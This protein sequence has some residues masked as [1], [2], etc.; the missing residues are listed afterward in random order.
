MQSYLQMQSSLMDQ[1]HKQEFTLLLTDALL[2]VVRAH[3]HSYVGLAIKAWL[4]ARLNTP[5]FCLSFIHF[6]IA[7]HIHL[8]IPHPIILHLSRC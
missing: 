7:L 8:S 5:S 2:N 6:L 3:L 1:L 4:L